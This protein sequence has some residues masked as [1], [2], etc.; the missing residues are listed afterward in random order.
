[1]FQEKPGNLGLVLVRGVGKPSV[2]TISLG[3]GKRR[4]I[5]DA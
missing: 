1:M 4:L 3:R 2:G 5:R